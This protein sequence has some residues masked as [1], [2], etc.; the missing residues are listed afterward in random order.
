[1]LPD[2][3]VDHGGVS[4]DPVTP[5]DQ[6]L[7][8]KPQQAVCGITVAQV[9]SIVFG[10]LTRLASKDKG[11]DVLRD[12]TD[13]ADVDSTDLADVP[14]QQHISEE[15][16]ISDDSSG[17]EHP[18]GQFEIPGHV[19]DHIP[20]DQ[21]NGNLVQENGILVQEDALQ[22]DALLVQENGM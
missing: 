13:L 8:G 20:M 18:G 16:H 14:E 10:M 1:M 22:D 21:E 7:A 11:A 2:M 19:D 12:S 9:E 15:E 4:L 5:G 6:M 3:M 17:D